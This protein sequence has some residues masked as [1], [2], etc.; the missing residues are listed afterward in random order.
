MN[1]SEPTFSMFRAPIANTTPKAAVTL[2]EVFDYITSDAA[3]DSTSQLR[4]LVSDQRAKFKASHFDYC[5]FSGIYSKR[6]GKGLVSHS[7]LIC[8]DFD[9]L[10][11]VEATFSTLILERYFPTLL[12][13]RSP[14]G[15]GLKWVISMR[16][17]FSRRAPY[18]PN[19]NLITYHDFFFS[20]VA[21]YLRDVYGLTADEQCKDIARACFLPYDPNAYLSS[22]LL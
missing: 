12:L 14:S 17:A 1:P 7:G 15:D 3:K 13:F 9:H 11:D 20:A 22:N 2:R 21:Q 16:E 10:P 5:T 4:T 18:F 19:D 8:F 6:S